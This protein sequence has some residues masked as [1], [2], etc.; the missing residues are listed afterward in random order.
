MNVFAGSLLFEHLPL[1]TFLHRII[2]QNASHQ[3]SLFIH[4]T[5]SH[6]Y[7]RFV[8][9]V[10]AYSRVRTHVRT[11]ENYLG[12]KVK[13][14]ELSTAAGHLL[15][16]NTDRSCRQVAPVLPFQQFV[17]IDFQYSTAILSREPRIPSGIHP[18]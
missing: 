16:T 9:V 6:F 8:R 4:T 1:L 17:R 12:E 11:V 13:P 7:S 15:A 3:L 5:P 14:F 10:N 18:T 2:S